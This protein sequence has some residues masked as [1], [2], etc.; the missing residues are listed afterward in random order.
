[1]GR[2]R[3]RPKGPALPA[4]PSLTST[5]LEGEAGHSF[6]GSLGD[7]NAL[8]GLIEAEP[9]QGATHHRIEALLQRNRGRLGTILTGFRGILSP[10][11]AQP[12]RKSLLGE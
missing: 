9:S 3:P 11:E 6:E 5:P 2:I 1:M 4:L 12:R 8:G 7:D 10:S